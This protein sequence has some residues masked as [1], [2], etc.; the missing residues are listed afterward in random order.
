VNTFECVLAG[1]E[2]AHPITI[3]SDCW[4]GGSAIILSRP[5]GLTIG[6]GVVVGA[7]AVVTRSVEPYVVVAGNPARV[8]RRLERPADGQ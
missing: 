7:G 1:P 8:I 2:F 3:G 5:G 6:D 4:F